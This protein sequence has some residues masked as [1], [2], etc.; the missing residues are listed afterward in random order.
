VLICAPS[1]GGSLGIFTTDNVG[2][3]GYNSLLDPGGQPNNQSYTNSFGGTSSATPLTS[4]IVALMLSAN[5]NLGYRDVMEILATTAV[6]IDPTHPD[7]VQNGAGFDFANPYGAGMVNAAAAV[8]RSLQWSNLPAVTS[9]SRTAT[10]LPAAIPDASATTVSRALDFATSPNLRVEHVEVVLTATHAN[11][12]DLEIAITSPSG[13]RSI[14]NPIR[15]RPNIVYT[16]DDDRNIG[17]PGNGWTFMSTHHWGEN[18]SGTWTVTA[19]RTVGLG[20]NVGRRAGAR[21]RHAL[22]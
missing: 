20:G 13:T 9:H 7:W 17:A 10:G 5:G 4:G 14:L 16:G 2:S 18:S 22:K 19:R 21:L 15:P 8:A 1:N 6:K 11:R 12:S 3:S